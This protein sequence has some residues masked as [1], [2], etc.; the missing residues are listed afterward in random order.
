ML[1]YAIDG[2][3]LTDAFQ[4]IYNDYFWFAFC[5]LLYSS[6]EK[7]ERADAPAHK[8]A[9]CHVRRITRFKCIPN[10]VWHFVFVHQ[11]YNAFEK[12]QHAVILTHIHGPEY[13]TDRHFCLLISRFFNAWQNEFRPLLCFLCM[14][15]EKM[16]TPHLIGAYSGQQTDTEANACFLGTTSAP[17]T[18][19]PASEDTLKPS[20]LTPAFEDTLKPSTLTPAHENHKTAPSKPNAC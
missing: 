19:T 9:N 7:A 12:A 14:R 18:P 6:F 2:H 8:L 13:I 3:Y 10:N 5:A 1:P 17:S 15:V 20:T 4:N 16:Q 11:E